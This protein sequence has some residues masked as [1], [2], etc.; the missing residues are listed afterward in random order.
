MLLLLAGFLHY[1]NIFSGI[2]RLNKPPC[3]SS[4]LPSCITE[5]LVKE[6]KTKQ[7]AMLLLLADF[8]HYGYIFSGITRLS[9]Q[10]CFSSMLASCIMDIS[11]QG[12]QD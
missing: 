4:L 11:F 3:I 7:A 5:D 6:H 10:S 2:T 12:S 9:K 8:L 1:G